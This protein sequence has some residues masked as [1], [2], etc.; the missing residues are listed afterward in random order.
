M[1]DFFEQGFPIRCS[2]ENGA[3][4]IWDLALFVMW[5]IT[6]IWNPVL[7]LDGLGLWP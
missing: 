6:L 1:L 2:T 7:H 3:D 5:N 4:C